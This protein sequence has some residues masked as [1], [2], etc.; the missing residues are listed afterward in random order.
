MVCDNLP[1]STLVDADFTFAND[2]LVQH[3]GL[4][5]LAGSRMRKVRLPKGCP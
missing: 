3:Y 2:R 1:A 5:T 4:P